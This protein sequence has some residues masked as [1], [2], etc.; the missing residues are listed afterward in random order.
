MTFKLVNM[1][2]NHLGNLIIGILLILLAIY[3]LIY[4]IP[5]NKTLKRK[6]AWIIIYIF[7]LSGGINNLL[8]GLGINIFNLFWN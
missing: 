1:D 4:W 7:V 5:R 8:S 6:W 2:I 3:Y